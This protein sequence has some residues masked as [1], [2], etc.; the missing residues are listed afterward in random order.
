MVSAVIS[1]LG[2]YLPPVV[3]D[4]DEVCRQIES[5]DEWIV[6]R[7][8]ISTRRRVPLGTSTSDIAVQAAER[9]LTS[10]G[11]RS[12]DMVVL[13]TATPDFISP[14]TAPI[15][16]DRLGLTGTP[17][18]DVSAA[19]S[20]FVYGLSVAS[21][22]VQSG[23]ACRV[24]FICAETA[25]YFTDPRDR[26]TAAI[27]GDGAAALVI[28]VG[29]GDESDSGAIGS[30]VMGADGSACGLVQMPGYAAAD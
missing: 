4:N 9:A 12:I 22:M 19:C 13:A 8:G 20:G 18:F 6:K 10:A 16:A 3:V 25:S 23:A 11:T 26:D 29:D 24:L 21:A 7:T 27:F 30:V 28:S 17:A 5:S 2:S 14:P 1:G 15:V